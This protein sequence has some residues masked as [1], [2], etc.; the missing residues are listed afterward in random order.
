[1]NNCDLSSQFM[2]EVAIAITRS[3]FHKAQLRHW[4]YTHIIH[5]KSN[6]TDGMCQEMYATEKFFIVLKCTVHKRNLFAVVCTVG[7]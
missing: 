4:S 2:V 6:N 7:L 5:L 3:G 1:M